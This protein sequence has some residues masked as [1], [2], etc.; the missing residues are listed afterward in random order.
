MIRFYSQ[1]TLE[2]WLGEVQRIIRERYPNIYGSK[3]VADKESWECFHIDGLTP[4]AAVKED[5]SNI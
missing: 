5:L 3:Y 2:Q 1:P 4:A